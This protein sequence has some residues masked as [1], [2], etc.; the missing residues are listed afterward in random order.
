[1][2]WKENVTRSVCS[3]A[4]LLL[5]PRSPLSGLSL[6]VDQSTTSSIPQRIL[7]HCTLLSPSNNLILVL[8]SIARP[9]VHT[10]LS[11]VP[12]SPSL[13]ASTIDTT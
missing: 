6:S 12:S 7:L 10:F 11:L 9:P 1:M 3:S 2:Q 5:S 13:S 4:P 8:H